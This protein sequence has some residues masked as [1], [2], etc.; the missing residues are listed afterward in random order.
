MSAARPALR[1][2]TRGSK[3]A[4]AQAGLVA[5]ELTARG[6]AVELV[7]IRTAGDERSP[8]GV[9]GEGAFVVALEEA[10]L[11]GRIDLAV[12][13]A[14][15]VP[16][17]GD[18]RL[19]IAAYLPREDPR[20]AL[21]CRDP[22]ATLATLP[23]GAT[24]GTDSPRRAAFIR[25][26][27][28][29]LVTQPL[30]GN[31]DTRL[32]KLAA[33]EADA[34]VLAV[35]G[36]RRLGLGD[37]I[38]E[39]LPAAEFLPAPGQG[40]LAVQVR[41]GDSAVRP[42]VKRLDEP[43][44]RAAVEAERA[45]LRASGGGCRAPLGALAEVEGATITIRGAAAEEGAVPLGDAPL[46]VAVASPG[47]TFTARAAAHLPAPRVVRGERRGQLADRLAL[48]AA[49]ARDLAAALAREGVSVAAGGS[50]TA[51]G[52]VV[53]EGPAA[54]APRVLVTREPGRPG[55]LALALA[56]RGLEP[57]VAPTVELRPVAPGGA[58]DEAAASLGR[59]A[60]VV[61]TSAAGAAALAEAAARAG[62]SLA[63]ARL[64]AVG[65]ATA[66]ALAA[67]GGRVEFLPSRATGAALAEELPFDHGEQILLARADAA[68]DALPALLRARGALVEEVV[69]YHTLEGPEAS[70]GAVQKA[71]STGVAA[72]AFTSG[73]TVRGLLALL[74]PSER[75]AA[76]RTPACCIGPTTA[77]V[78]RSAGFEHVVETGASTVEALGDLVAATCTGAQ[79]GGPVEPQPA[80]A[81]R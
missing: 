76:V 34:I 5:D 16:T 55:A 80:E 40:A 27:R 62:A 4:L 10:L 43:A 47:T 2:G 52:L 23:A 73:S 58:L 66:E 54:G 81:S 71:L 77:G 13:S 24:I 29:D 7:V 49:L 48:A 69:A 21:V 14:K 42:L 1:L 26:R 31:V 41:A 74:G 30:H 37:S 44:S 64:A 53:A 3:L 32:R 46:T 59:Y 35:A 28:P 22:A 61:V 12:H 75:K 45:F 70:R 57:V 33:G 60:W 9:W 72:I 36:L 38:T 68:E 39:V 6:A 17:A 15:D 18:P 8:S 19:A 25:S 67:R 63:G 51:G 56:A 65:G 20:D 79:L 11:D 78:A 50:A